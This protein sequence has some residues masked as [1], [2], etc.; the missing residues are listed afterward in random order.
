MT[1]TH[2]HTLGRTLLDGGSAARREDLYQAAHN[3][4]K[5]QT[6]MPPAGDY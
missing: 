3:S 2:T 5:T 4:R 6:P 1:H